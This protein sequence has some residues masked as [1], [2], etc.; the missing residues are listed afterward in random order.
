MQKIRYWM[1]RMRIRT[2]LYML[3]SVVVLCFSVL[4]ITYL[5]NIRAVNRAS[6]RQYLQLAL[7]QLGETVNTFHLHMEQVGRELAFNT[8]ANAFIRSTN[9]VDWYRNY[10]PLIAV[11]NSAQI[12]DR[13]LERIVYTDLNMLFIGATNHEDFVSLWTIVADIKSG[14]LDVSQP[15]HIR[16]GEELFYIRKSSYNQPLGRQFY[17]VIRYSNTRFTSAIE[18]IESSGEQ[19]FVLYNDQ[20]Q[21]LG[22]NATSWG[23]REE[24]QRLLLDATEDGTFYDSGYVVAV[25][26]IPDFGW[27][28]VTI[29]AEGAIG[30]QLIH[31][32]QFSLLLTGTLILLLTL[33]AA[34]IQ[35]SITKPILYVNRFMSE[36]KE[37]YDSRRLQ[38]VQ[39]NEIGELAD[40]LN[41]ML[42]QIGTMNRDMI[43]A[44]KQIYESQLDKQHMELSALYSQINPHFLYNTLDCIRSIAA[45]HGVEPIVKITSSMAKIFR[46]SIKSRSFVRVKEEMACIYE[47]MIILQTRYQGAFVEEY[48]I[49]EDC[50]DLIIPKMVLQPVVE[51]A[52]FHGLEQSRKRGALRVFCGIREGVLRFEI[53][54]NGKGMDQ[55]MLFALRESL[56]QQ[57]LMQ[58]HTLRDK[59][60]IGL[61]NIHARIRLLCGEQYGMQVDSAP[62]LGTKVVIAL[63]VLHPEDIPDLGE[64]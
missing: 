50:Q 35:Q 4:Q 55:D 57:N 60:S 53:S 64:S 46:Y 20:G 12:A 40:K 48:H 59:K 24:V 43:K 51:N 58:D 28:W 54:D 3:V 17:L 44:Q 14:A 41:G 42:T 37:D 15:R 25:R 23:K 13:T 36:I 32:L 38:L 61:R 26:N 29:A 11:I 47:Y 9:A 31:F 34:M 19:L 52:V 21:V 8:A 1:G 18:A 62:D 49:D 30:D 10:A 2:L 6:A 45:I 7:V 27:R 63:P 33:V 39:D 16:L 22:S 56:R 5:I